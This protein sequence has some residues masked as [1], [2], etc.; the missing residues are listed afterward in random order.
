LDT[1]SQNAGPSGYAREVKFEFKESSIVSLPGSQYYGGL[2]TIAPWSDNSGGLNHQFGLHDSGFSYRSGLP[3][4]S[5]WGAWRRVLIESVNGSVGIGTTNPSHKL[6]LI[7]TVRACEVKVDISGADFVFEADYERLSLPELEEYINQ[8]KRLPEIQS[9]MEMQEQGVNLGSFNN[10]LL[11][12][13]EELTL[14]IIEINNELM[15]LKKE[16]Q[17]LRD[18]I[19]SN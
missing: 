7:G 6:D 19:I 14:Y 12:K 1:R 18:N 9:A 5:T 16:N 3:Q 17:R 8:H 10:Q 2:L 15:K 13:I 4:S 11:Q